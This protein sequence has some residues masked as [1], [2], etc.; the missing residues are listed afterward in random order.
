MA[1]DDS[2]LAFSFMRSS[3]SSPHVPAMLDKLLLKASAISCWLAAASFSLRSCAKARNLK[4][5]NMCCNRRL[6]HRF[7][8][9]NRLWHFWLYFSLLDFRISEYILMYLLGSLLSK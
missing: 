7:K 4:A 5:L 3:P 8:E 9:E 2:I 6:H 1:S